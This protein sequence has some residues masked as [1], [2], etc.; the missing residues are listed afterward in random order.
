LAAGVTDAMISTQVAS[1]RLVQVRR[2]VFVGADGWPDAAA[3][4][5]LVR[6]H[7][8]QVAN[9]AAVISHQSAAVVWGLPSPGFDEW[10]EAPVSLTLPPTF[11]GSRS[12]ST[13]WHVAELPARHV[14][15]DEDGYSVTSLARTAVDLAAGLALP[16]ALVVLDGAGRQL[17]ASFVTSPRRSDHVNPRLVK[18]VRDALS[19]VLSSRWRS[20]LRSAID[21][22]EPCRESA[23]ESLTAGYLHLS[24]LPMPQFQAKIV[25]SKGTYYPDCYWPALRLIGEC[26]GAAKYA[27]PDAFV[28]E[29]IREQVLRDEGNR[30]VRWLGKEIML[31]PQVVMNR[32]GAALNR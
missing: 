26:D 6:A 8:E 3:G 1:G 30:F 16:R 20:Q 24:G 5:H 12:T 27:Q 28:A 18:A 11:H 13:V 2:G 14:T 32:I 15:R 9:P 23:A 31:S 7:A 29:K 22:V 4:Q 10:H 19:D 21:C 17:V 25:T